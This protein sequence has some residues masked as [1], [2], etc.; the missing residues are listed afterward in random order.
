M[1]LRKWFQSKSSNAQTS[2]AGTAH[3][4]Q[5]DGSGEDTV[6]T[7]T[8][9]PPA[10]GDSL[11][12]PP[13]PVRDEGWC[14]REEIAAL[15]HVRDEKQLAQ[16]ISRKVPGAGREEVL[17]RYYLSRAVY[18]GEFELPVL[19]RSATEVLQLSRNPAAEIDDYVRVIG[20]DPSLLRGIV[21]TANSPFFASL[22]GTTSLDQAI[23]RIGLRQVE[24][25][26]MF[27]AMRSK[28]FRVPGYEALI[29]SLTAH[30]I[31]AA[32]AAQIVAPKVLALP[33]DAFLSG[34]FHDVGKLVLISVIGN[35]QKRLHWQAPPA[36]VASCFET[37]HVSFG[38]VVCRHWNFPAQ[39]CE[40]V[41]SHHDAKRAAEKTLDRAVYLGNLLAHAMV[42]EDLSSTL[43]S[44]YVARASNLDQ[45]DLEQVQAEIEKEM[46][47]YETIGS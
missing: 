34:V 30:A 26:T 20:G 31:T 37:Y 33:A 11:P 42:D 18:L 8:M 23:V 5:R 16:V 40:A 14:T 27:H 29:R 43:A 41:G 13:A 9:E 17:F 2:D 15:R 25:L 44:D 4:K 6:A 1:F 39:I 47:A 35:V 3:L 36:L 21:D 7:A 10:E 32:V 12:E 24:Q 38:E 46:Q 22:S 45:A 28:I 19:P